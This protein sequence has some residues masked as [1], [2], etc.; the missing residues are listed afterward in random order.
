MKAK[1]FIAALA[2]AGLAGCSDPVGS[3][4]TGVLVVETEASGD[5]IPQFS[6]LHIAGLPSEQ[7]LTNLAQFVTTPIAIGPRQV[8]LEVAANCTVADNPRS[9]T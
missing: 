7:I 8:R 3:G 9:S 5:N 1:Y 4:E 6:S 2:L